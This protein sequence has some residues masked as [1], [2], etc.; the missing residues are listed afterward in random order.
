MEERLDFVNG[1]LG[2]NNQNGTLLSIRIPN[3]VQQLSEE[4]LS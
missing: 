2:I 1:S 4:R 3:V